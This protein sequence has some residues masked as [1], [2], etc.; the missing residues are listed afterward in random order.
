MNHRGYVRHGYYHNHKNSAGETQRKGRPPFP[1]EWIWG[2]DNCGHAGMSAW[3]ESCP[4][5]QHR[6]CE[7]CLMEP[8]KLTRTRLER[9]TSK[10][11]FVLQ[12]HSNNTSLVQTT[13]TSSSSF[14]EYVK[15]YESMPGNWKMEL[16]ARRTCSS[17]RVS[18]IDCLKCN[19]EKPIDSNATTSQA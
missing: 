8:A 2:C 12:K 3:I 11:K 16:M 14:I 19:S 18:K 6:R 17:L 13:D 1:C 9:T 7:Q 5:C 10:D 4:E 15:P